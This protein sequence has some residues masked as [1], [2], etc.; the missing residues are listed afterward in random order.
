MVKCTARLRLACQ[1]GGRAEDDAEGAAEKEKRSATVVTVSSIGYHQPPQT[2]SLSPRRCR[3]SA[4][5]ARSP[6]KI[7][8]LLSPPIRFLP[9]VHAILSSSRSHSNL[10]K[11]AYAFLTSL[12]YYRIFTTKGS[13]GSPSFS[14]ISRGNYTENEDIP[15]VE[16]SQVRSKK[17]ER[18]RTGGGC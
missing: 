4:T 5:I 17:S 15:S 3:F 10:E 1:G 2:L 13:T 16:E 7:I 9:S 6:R 12:R 11:F 8:L 14:V 18:L